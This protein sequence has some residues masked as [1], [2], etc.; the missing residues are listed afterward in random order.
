MHCISVIAK[1][2]LFFI[3]AYSFSMLK[4]GCLINKMDVDTA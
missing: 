3:S 2:L 1:P 4:F